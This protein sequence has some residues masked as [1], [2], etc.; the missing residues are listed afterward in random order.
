M[1]TTALAIALLLATQA[2]PSGQAKTKPWTPPRTPDGHPDLQGIWDYRSA[3]PLQ[4]PAR[5]AGKEFLTPDEVVAYEQEALERPDGR[6]PDDARTEESVHPVWWLDYGKTVVKTRR[7][8]LIVDP[9]DGRIPPFT[10]DAQKRFDVRQRDEALHPADRPSDR[11]LTERCILFGATVPMLPE[12]YNNNYRI[13]Q[14]PGVV[15]IAVEMNHDTRVIPIDGR[16]PIG[17][18]IE[19]WTGSSRGRWDGDT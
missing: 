2:L 6:P 19:Q 18:P 7:T 16:P 15:T 14:S 8:S 12:P 11:W 4:R 3:T 17:A 5:F 13:V 1:R 10:P 9:P